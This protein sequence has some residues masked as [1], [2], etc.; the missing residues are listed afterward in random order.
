VRL[1]FFPISVIH[2]SI[3]VDESSSTVSFVVHPV[4]LVD[5]TVYPELDALTVFL[6]LLVPLT[7]ITGPIL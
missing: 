7:F 1:V 5:R 6:V 4:A 2:V 3:C